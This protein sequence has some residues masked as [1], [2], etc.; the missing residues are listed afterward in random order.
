MPTLV[1]FSVHV[2]HMVQC[3][4]KYTHLGG[5][6][7]ALVLRLC[8]SELG[9]MMVPLVQRPVKKNVFKTT[10]SF[11]KPHDATATARRR[12]AI[13]PCAA[14]AVVDRRPPTAD[15]RPLTVD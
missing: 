3:Q 6:F 8:V 12:P 14:A 15:R 11:P 9:L 10:N 2:H 5:F 4:S 1:A 13:R 7:G